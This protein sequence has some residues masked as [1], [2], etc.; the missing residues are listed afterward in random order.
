[1]NACVDVIERLLE[2][3]VPGSEKPRVSEDL[4]SR[5]WRPKI[6]PIAKPSN[7]FVDCRREQE[8]RPRRVAPGLSVVA[9][10]TNISFDNRRGEN[11]RRPIIKAHLRCATIP[12][13]VA[14]HRPRVW[15]PSASRT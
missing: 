4:A 2:F 1:M 12:D 11:S 7:G 15:C 14:C 10:P 9:Q 5:S 8:G 3:F 6:M 13:I